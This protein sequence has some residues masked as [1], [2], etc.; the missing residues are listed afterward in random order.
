M[1]SALD[2]D[3]KK[4]LRSYPWQNEFIEERLERNLKERRAKPREALGLE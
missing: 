2:K 1:A 3:T 4:N